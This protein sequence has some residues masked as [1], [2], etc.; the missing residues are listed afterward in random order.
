MFYRILNLILLCILCVACNRGAAPARQQEAV[1][2][3]RKITINAR[4][5][6][7]FTFASPKGEFKTVSKLGDV[8]KAQRGW[9]RVV[10]LEMKQAQ[11]RDHQMV[12]V[13]DLRTPRKDGSYPYVVLSR[14]AFELPA[15]SDPGGGGQPGKLPPGA[16][17]GKGQV[18]LYATSWCGACAAARKYLT[19]K[20]IP[21]V[22]KD[23]EEDKRAAAE[24]L[25]KASK[26]GISASGVPV[27]DVGGTLVQGFD[28]A[29]I[30]TLLAPKGK[31]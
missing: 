21:F 18:I 30:E 24:L 15:K 1:T 29:R 31:P 20:G 2:A 23:I 19:A 4:A 11:R 6:M 25:Q 14:A 26:A 10:D 12:Y 13:A 16:V 8:P 3:L 28:P 27:L 9:V 5:N 22:E 7:L 17:A